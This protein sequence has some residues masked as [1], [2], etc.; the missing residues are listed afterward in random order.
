MIDVFA[1]FNIDSKERFK[2]MKDSFFSFND[3]KIINKW[4]IN[5]RGKYKRSAKNFLLKNIKKKKYIFNIDYKEGWFQETKYMLKYIESPIV[6]FWIEDHILISKKN[7]FNKIGL[8]FYNYDLDIML[9]SF[10]HSGQYIRNFSSFF[11][12]ET[13]N[14]FTLNINKN[15]FAKIKKNFLKCEIDYLVS[16]CSFFSKNFFRELIL[17]KDKILRRYPKKTPFNFEKNLSDSHWLPIKKAYPKFELF[18]SIDD[19]QLKNGYSLISR[20]L[21]PDRT[22]KKKISKINNHDFN[23]YAFYIYKLL[24]KIINKVY[25]FLFFKRS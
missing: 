12:Q 13:K 22:S 8:D 23:I 20:G 24:E 6:F 9:Y 1:N 25:V 19:N 16:C 15:T 3:C 18:A 10:F 2:R 21:Y 14:F 7:Y 11:D 4:V 17:N 5:I